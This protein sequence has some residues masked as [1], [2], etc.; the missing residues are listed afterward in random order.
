MSIFVVLHNLHN[1]QYPFFIFSSSFRGVFRQLS[2]SY[3]LRFHFSSFHFMFRQVK[4][5]TDRPEKKFH[6]FIGA[7]MQW[8]RKL[9][10]V[11]PCSATELNHT[12]APAKRERKKPKSIYSEPGICLAE[13]AGCSIAAKMRAQKGKIKNLKTLFARP[14]ADFKCF[15]VNGMA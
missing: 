13:I 8:T 4:R 1:A 5:W 11:V 14:L 15:L 12:Q 9:L 7:E 3:E 6:Y 10:P 2:T